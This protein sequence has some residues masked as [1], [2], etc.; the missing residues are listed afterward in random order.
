MIEGRGNSKDCFDSFIY[1]RFCERVKERRGKRDGGRE[2][3][4]YWVSGVREIGKGI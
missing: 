2:D 1:L 4:R 3:E